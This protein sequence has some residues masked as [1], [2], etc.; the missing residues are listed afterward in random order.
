MSAPARRIPLIAGNWKMNLDHLQAIA[1]VQKLSWGLKDVKHDFGAVEVAV[2]PPFTDLR[3]VQTLISADKLALQLGAQD[4]SPHASGA[5]TGDIAASV[6]KKL[7]VG[8][9]IVGHS[10]R[11]QGHA[12]GG[13]LVAAK[14][15][16]T[17]AEG[18]IPVICVGE[19]AADLDEHGAAAIPL[20]QLGE[21]LAELPADAEFVV[22]YEPVWAI[23]RGEAASPEQ[24]E[25]VCRALRSLITELRGDA[26]AESTR[27]LYGGS[28]TS[29]NVAAFLRQA[30]IDGALVGGASLDAAEFAR[31]V[32]FEK[33]V[34]GA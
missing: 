26:V 33:H 11:R 12:E 17:H 13:A 24:A 20:Q 28:V 30:N 16:A 25:D 8:Y 32:Q 3:S 15:R 4:V 14:A 10:E 18:M 19:T 21:A 7:E 27:V 22:A 2:F 5:H 23:G 1:L 34:I 31:I 29:Q 9:V 6:L